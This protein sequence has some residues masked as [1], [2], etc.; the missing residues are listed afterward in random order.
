MKISLAV[1]SSIL[2]NIIKRDFTGTVVR[3]VNNIK[4]YFIETVVEG[5]NGLIS[6]TIGSSSVYF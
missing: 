2:E 3:V 5:V 4:T 1:S 6:L